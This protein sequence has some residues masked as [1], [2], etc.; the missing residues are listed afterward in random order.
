MID[1]GRGGRGADHTVSVYA[2]ANQIELLMA[3]TWEMDVLMCGRP[4]RFA[5]AGVMIDYA[6][7]DANVAEEFS[8]RWKALCDESAS[9]RQTR[10]SST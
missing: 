2:R 1:D 10:T 7:G 3:L 5:G 6:C 8:A 4:Q 9:T